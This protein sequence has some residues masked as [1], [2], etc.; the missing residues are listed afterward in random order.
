MALGNGKLTAADDAIAATAVDRP[1]IVDDA[2]NCDEADLMQVFLSSILLI[3]SRIA[4]LGK[5]IVLVDRSRSIY[6]FIVLTQLVRGH[7]KPDILIQHL[8]F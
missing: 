6:G 8:F 3:F 5:L 1:K 4:C 7:R 2:A